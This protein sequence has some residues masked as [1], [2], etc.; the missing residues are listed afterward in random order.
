MRSWQKIKTQDEKKLINENNDKYCV[1][2]RMTFIDK[3]KDIDKVKKRIMNLSSKS[4]TLVKPV[5]DLIDKKIRKMRNRSWL[6]SMIIKNK[7]YGMIVQ[8][9]SKE[10]R[11]IA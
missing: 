6:I 10:R 11:C 8:K 2:E 1:M 3:F 7:L 4:L 9:K 5:R